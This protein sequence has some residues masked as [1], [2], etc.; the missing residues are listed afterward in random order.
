MSAV[1]RIRQ[2][3]VSAG[4]RTLHLQVR[5]QLFLCI[6]RKHKADPV[7]LPLREAQGPFT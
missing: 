6:S 5:G 7:Q 4:T 3:L 2:G 1:A